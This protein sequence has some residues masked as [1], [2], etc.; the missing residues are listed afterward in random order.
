VRRAIYL[1]WA[2]S[3]WCIG[4]GLWSLHLATSEQPGLPLSVPLTQDVERS[5]LPDAP[6]LPREVVARIYFPTLHSARN[7]FSGDIES[8]G[9]RGPVWLEASASVGSAGNAIVAGH[10]DT[11]FRILKDLRVND[12]IVVQNAVGTYRYRV[13]KLTVVAPTDRSL[14]RQ[15][16]ASSLT[17]VTCYPFWFVGS[18][19]R[20]YIVQAGLVAGP[21][22]SIH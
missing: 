21:A 7:V 3:A 22:H 10:R 1:L 19:P 2:A 9:R 18:A 6:Q 12:E 15:D 11:H 13:E 4:S 5:S 17:L 16:I 8:N 14:L 20:R